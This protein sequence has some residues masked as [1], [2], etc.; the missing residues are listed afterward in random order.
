MS[1]TVR[2]AI[3]SDIHYAGSAEQAR[4]GEVLTGIANPALRW[5]IKY[6]RHYIWMR[7]PFAHNH[8]LD[9]FIEQS[10]TPDYAIA[11]G[12]YSCDTAYVGVSDE[13]SFASAQ[14]CLQKL[15][16]QFGS[17]FRASYGDHELGKK[18]L[19]CDRGGLRF[20][21]WIRAQRDLKLQP[22]WQVEVGNYVLMG[23]V[24][25][26]AALP[27][28]L[29]E[30]LPAEA[31][32]WQAIRQAHLQEISHAFDAL[33]SHQRV[34]LFCHD[35]TALP[36]LYRLPSVQAKL[37]QI[38]RTVIG[39]LHS[40]LILRQ[41][42]MLGGIPR[43]RLGHTT[44]RVTAALREVRYWKPFRVLLCP[45]LAG[46]ELLKDGGFYTAELDLDTNKPANFQLRRLGR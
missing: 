29:A 8:L 17:R 42:Y 32:E 25:T 35:P 2:L 33:K 13:A 36:F 23:I 27:V 38:E 28:Y 4:R 26:L 31:A 44:Q 40:S 21:S 19:G 22:F 37:S 16:T 45:A 10:G 14:E 5:L 11:N 6:Y 18:K 39:H 34:L 7:D 43:L 3:V 12:D 20:E 9:Q 15:H 30:A 1:R 41:S 24:S 46:I